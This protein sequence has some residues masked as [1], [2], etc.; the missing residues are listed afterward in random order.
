LEIAKVN[1]K[2]VSVTEKQE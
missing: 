1:P 2:Y